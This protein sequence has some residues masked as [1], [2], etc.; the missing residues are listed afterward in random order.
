MRSLKTRAFL[1]A[2][3]LALGTTGAAAAG[4]ADRAVQAAA[5]PAAEEAEAVMAKRAED[6]LA[7]LNGKAAPAT[8]FAPELIEKVTEQRLLNMA[9]NI[10]AKQGQALGV[11]RIETTDAHSATVYIDFAK[12]QVPVQLQLHPK[13]PHLI[14]GLH[15]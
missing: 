6:L 7:V 8:A 4:A 12:V 9:A 13:A 11:G 15:I 5:A 10:R 3:T 2:A 14:I 1:I